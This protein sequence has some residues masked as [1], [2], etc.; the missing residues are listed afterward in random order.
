MRKAF[1]L[2]ELL[3]VV[4]IIGVVYNLA[5]GSFE[6]IAKPQSQKITLQNLKSFLAKIEYKK[7][8]K[9]LCLDDC[10][11]CNL[12][13]DGAVDEDFEKVFEDFL[14]LSVQT[15]W[16]D[17]MLGVVEYQ[18]KLYFD[19]SDVEK[20]VCFSYAMGRDRIGEQIVVKFKDKVYDFSLYA[21]DAV[22][23]DSL[24]EFIESKEKL[25]N[26]VVR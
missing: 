5:V 19:S 4:I 25:Y 23:Y 7:Q 17:P 16:Y 3:I 21:D 8:I 26:K 6:K 24:L 22:L 18:Q 9:L 1:S 12:F 13:I 14:D 11:R 10:S 15:Y 20:R 2:V